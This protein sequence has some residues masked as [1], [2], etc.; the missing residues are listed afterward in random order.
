[1]NKIAFVLWMG[2]VIYTLIYVLFIQSD[3]P[4]LF[5]ILNGAADPFAS[6]FFNLMGLVPFYFLLDYLFF[7]AHSRWGI[8]TFLFGFI[9][10]AFSIL[11]G[12]KKHRSIE[13]SIPKWVQALL[14]I[15][16]ILTSVIITQ[17][18]WQGNPNQYFQLFMQDSL[19]GI[20]T[21]DFLV[22]YLWSLYRSKQLFRYWYL[23]FIPMVGFG[24]L[25]LLHQGDKK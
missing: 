15:L 19:V 17:A 18:F 24:L 14:M 13:V 8:V 9:G 5:E 7:Q 10:G 6:Q 3:S 25:M 16:I 2:L 20:M 23:S 21:I 22:L 1:M 12:Y 11:I 4:L